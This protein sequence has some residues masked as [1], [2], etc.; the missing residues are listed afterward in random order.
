MGF[1]YEECRKLNPRLIYASISGYAALHQ[2][3]AGLESPVYFADA[4]LPDCAQIRPDR[5][6]RQHTR[7]RCD[8]VRRG[9]FVVKFSPAYRVRRP[10]SEA[11]AG[12]MHITG[13]EDGPPVKVGV[14]VTGQFR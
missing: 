2:V 11:E 7:L 8:H 14:A 9:E 4:L 10:D 5:S 6:L 3:T 13:E 12:L 1:S